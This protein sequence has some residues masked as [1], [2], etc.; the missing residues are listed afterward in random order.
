MDE[1][2]PQDREK[3]NARSLSR[4]TGTGRQPWHMDLAHRLEPARYLVMGMYE[5]TPTAASTE[6]LDTSMLICD[7]HREAAF[8]EPFLIRTGVSSFYATMTSKSQPFVRF[9]PG[10]M[11]GATD[12]AKQLMQKVLDQDLPANCGR[13]MA[14]A[15]VGKFVTMHTEGIGG[16]DFAGKVT[17]GAMATVAG[18]LAS[19]AGGGKF[20]DGAT[21]AA[22]GYLFNEMLT[23]K[24]GRSF[25]SRGRYYEGDR[26]MSG[27]D[28][29]S[30]LCSSAPPTTQEIYEGFKIAATPLGIARTATLF[31][32]LGVAGHDFYSNKVS[33]G[34]LGM[35]SIAAGTG[36]EHMAKPIGKFAGPIGHIVGM[37]YDRLA[38][39]DKQ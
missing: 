28:P 32:D 37:G 31:I 3:A 39:P 24:Q 35:G 11:Q 4:I 16:D 9:D 29:G 18:G 15:L 34:A 7:Q 33:D 22:F 21:T 30:C 36:V 14:S 6:L 25:K 17:R 1:L 8:S 12:H 5:C 19:V 26:T 38:K 10:C 2:T 27:Y 23:D 13:G 20:D